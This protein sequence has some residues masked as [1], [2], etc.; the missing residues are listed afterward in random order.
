MGKSVKEGVMPKEYIYSQDHGR[1]AIIMVDGDGEHPGVPKTEVLDT[2]AIKVGWS[3]E[4][5]H[6]GLCVLDKA[7]DPDG[8]E[9]QHI[10]LDRAGLNRLIKVLRQARD[11]A[12]GR[13]E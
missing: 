13:D 7:T 9:A 11:D 3:K 2:L 12:Y 4:Q 6:V 10:N 5:E 1:E 8:F